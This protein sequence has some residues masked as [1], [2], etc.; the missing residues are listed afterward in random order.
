M[1]IE[2]NLIIT[3]FS[4]FIAI[5]SALTD[6]N[7]STPILFNDT[8]VFGICRN[9]NYELGGKCEIANKIVKIQWI[10]NVIFIDMPKTIVFFQKYQNGDLILE[11][12]PEKGN[13]TRQFYKLK[14]N[15][16]MFLV[17]DGEFT[18]SL[19]LNSNYTSTY[20]GNL[21]LIKIREN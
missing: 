12:L 7:K 21:F 6:C 15:E 19:T 3:L 4:S 20:N 11:I 8:C 9:G 16:E 1:F 18:P 17:K 10:T 2:M 5:M 14:Q 13:Y